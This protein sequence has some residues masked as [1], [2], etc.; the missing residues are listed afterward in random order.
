MKNEAIGIK[1]DGFKPECT[2]MQKPESM[3][4]GMK[5]VRHLQI[6]TKVRAVIK[7]ALADG[8]PLSNR[9]DLGQGG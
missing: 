9:G 5:A 4:G 3:I 1:G 6:E 7:A 2:L 8:I